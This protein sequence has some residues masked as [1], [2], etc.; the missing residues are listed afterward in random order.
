VIAAVVVTHA[1]PA[2]TLAACID[3][4]R[5][6]RGVDRIVVVDNGGDA[7]VGSDDVDLI[8]TPNRGYGAAANEGFRRALE[9]GASAIALLNDDVTVH[10]G[11]AE[12]LVAALAERGVGAAQPK[13]LIA[14]SKPARIN[15]L[16]VVIGRDGAGNDIGDGSLDVVVGSSSV[17]DRFT[18]GAV[19]FAPEFIRETGGFDERFFLYYEDVDLGARGTELG[20]SYTLVPSSVVEH[21]RSAT[22]ASD[23]DHTRYLQ[24]RNRLWH[25]FRHCDAGT[26]ARALWLSVRRLRHRPRT[27]HA[28]ALGAGLAGAPGAWWRRAR[29]A[30]RARS[31]GPLR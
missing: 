19:M 23:S 8:V 25:A 10:A 12:P 30:R 17:I 24:E 9:L 3:S 2:A 4:I 20:W 26:Q 28:H 14:G 29:R 7:R 5:H 21:E 15:S 27:V 1:A 6:A 31:T 16:G 11:W 22:T 18:G 13:L